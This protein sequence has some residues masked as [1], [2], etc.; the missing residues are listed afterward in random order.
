MRNLKNDSHY[1]INYCLTFPF[2][3]PILSFE[4]TEEEIGKLEE[5]HCNFLENF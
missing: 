3:C 2:S 1:Q 5:Y 4:G